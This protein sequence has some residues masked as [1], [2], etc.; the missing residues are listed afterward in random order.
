MLDKEN[1][2]KQKYIYCVYSENIL[3]D[4]V[5]IERFPIIYINNKYVYFKVPGNESL[6]LKSI[7]SVKDSLESLTDYE[8]DCLA[9]NHQY[10]WTMDKNAPETLKEIKEKRNQKILEQKRKQ[11]LQ[12]LYDAKRQYDRAL[13]ICR[14]YE[15][16]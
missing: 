5:H 12:D 13:D 15:E 14:R 7:S 4:K 16:N 11:A 2:S 10:F 8:I 3:D 1:L 9:W 6:T